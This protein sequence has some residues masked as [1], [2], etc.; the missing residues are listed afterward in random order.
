M[1]PIAI[2]ETG[3][4]PMLV[5]LAAAITEKFRMKATRTIYQIYVR[6]PGSNLW[7]QHMKKVK[8]GLIP[9]RS[10]TPEKAN[11]EAVRIVHTT[12]Y[13]AM[14]TH[15]NVRKEP[16]SEDHPQYALLADGDTLY[17]ASV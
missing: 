17:R 6:P 9:W 7:T 13:C 14:V 8:G 2:Q 15:V 12:R 16:D 10:S 11:E 1:K 5:Q 3:H 4:A